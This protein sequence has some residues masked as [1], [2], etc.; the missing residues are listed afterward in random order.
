MWL[1]T[2][3]RFPEHR[4]IRRL[5]DG[6]Y[7]LHHTAMCACAKDETDGYITKADLADM[8]HSERLAKYIPALVDAGLWE[9]VDEGWLIHDFLD[10]NPSH[11]QQDEK[12]AADRKRQEARRQRLIDAKSG[13]DQ[14]PT[15]PGSEGDTPEITPRSQG[16][17]STTF[18]DRSPD[19]TSDPD[20][21][22]SQDD[23]SRRDSRVSHSGVTRESRDPV[24]SRPV[25][26]RP[27][28]PNGS[29]VGATKRG[30]RLAVDFVPSLDSR[31]RILAEFPTLDLAREH[32]RFVDYWRAEPGQRGVKVD[33]DATWRNWMRREGEK[34]PPRPTR[35]DETDD[36][37]ARAAARL[38]ATDQLTIEG[39]I[40]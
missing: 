14:T 3:D 34:R 32:E 9:E 27:T 39:P 31:K 26:S 13:V 25:P 29:V 2:D 7:R 40:L 11:A 17:K 1:K 5:S 8:Q 19:R 37:F 15:L 6:A 22:A 20:G 4:K 24:P 18:P 28:D 35:Q 12:R 16:K 10:Y 38:G 36:M 30:T 33:W 21:D 23:V